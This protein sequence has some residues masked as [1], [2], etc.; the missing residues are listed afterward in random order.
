MRKLT[1]AVA[2]VMFGCG[3]G[4]KY[5]IDD[6]ALAS[7][8]VQE[9]Q[10]ILAAQNE[11]NQARAEHQ[12]AEAE[13]KNVDRELDIAE[14]EL[15]AAKLTLDTA[16]MNKKGA[17]QSGDVNRKN[18]A[19]RDVQVAEMGVKAAKAKVSWLEKKKKWAK[20]LRDAAEKHV[21]AA[22]AKVELEKAKLASMKGIRPSE[23]FNVANFET[24]TMNK[25]KKYSDERLDADKLRPEVDDLERKWR[26]LDEQYQSARRAS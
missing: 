13:V 22:D 2:V 21:R 3:G 24:E 25:M 17:E 12:Q 10:G 7:V 14:N 18:V 26:S 6:A 1:L 11:Q 19:N 9:R 5:R 20:Q 15:K 16:E 8:P 4:P 23:D